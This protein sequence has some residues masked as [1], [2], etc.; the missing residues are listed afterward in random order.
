M[1]ELYTLWQQSGQTKK[2]FCQQEDIPFSTFQYWS[3]K[4]SEASDNFVSLNVG[5]NSST[6]VIFPNGARITFQE[7]VSASFLRSLVS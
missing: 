5:G 6:E 7:P 1:E 2:A 4:L 3:K